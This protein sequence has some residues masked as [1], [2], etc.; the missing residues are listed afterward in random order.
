MGS[1][2]AVAPAGNAEP[3]KS[4]IARFIGV[5]ISPGET[6]E[7]IVRHPGF[8]APAIA[9]IV[10]AWAL[11]DTMYLKLGMETV[12][13]ISLERSPFA[14]RMTPEQIQQA[15]ANSA[16]HL[17][18]TLVIADV[19]ILIVI[20]MLLAILAGLGILFVN[21]IFGGE[22]KFK[23]LVSVAAYANL[24]PIIGSILG[25]VIILF[26][27]TENL[28]PQNP[29]PLNLAFF[30][31]YKEVSKPLFSLAGSVDLMVIWL[32]VLLGIGMSKASG[33]RAKTLSVTFCFVGAWALWIVAKVALS[34]LF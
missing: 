24:V 23:T 2:V 6:F 20:P 16:E 13:R 25:I 32:V 7:D 31:N 17:T 26:G 4:F 8:I 22:A 27:G 18:R 29:V 14:S 30:L 28:D 12:T 5:I 33:G 9:S 19:S 1:P 34:M 11:I 21:A 3:P 15:I 10:T